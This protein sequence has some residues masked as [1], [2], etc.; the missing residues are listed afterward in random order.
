MAADICQSHGCRSAPIVRRAC[1]ELWQILAID[2][3]VH[4]ESNGIARQDVIDAL[5]DM[6]ASAAIPPDD[7][8]LIFSECFKEPKPNSGDSKE[9]ATDVRLEDFVAY[10]PMHNYIFTPT[11]E[12]W[13]SSSVNARIPPIR[14]SSASA[15][16][17]ANAPVEQ[18]TWAPGLPMLIKNKLISEGGW[19]ERKGVT[20]FNLYRPPTIERGDPTKV[21]PWLNHV[22]KVYGNDNKHIIKW[23]AQRVQRPQEKI[24]HALVFGG[25]QGIGK[26]SLLEP[27]KR[28][29]GPWNFYEVSPQQMSL[30][31]IFE[32]GDPARERGT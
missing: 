15:W 21:E 9:P 17:D 4:P 27:V 6:A 25:K 20:C 3:T 32:I 1:G 11:R 7:M 19:I 31:W 22:G 2:A 18:M 24:N 13:P 10:M 26:D 5:H 14:K 8:Q 30:Q 29:I 12:M 23:L 28:A 16:L